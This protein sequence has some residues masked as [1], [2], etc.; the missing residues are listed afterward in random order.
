M[1]TEWKKDIESIIDIDDVVAYENET[2]KKWRE[3]VEER[4]AEICSF[5]DYGFCW[6]DKGNIAINNG[7]YC[8]W[9]EEYYGFFGKNIE[10][11]ITINENLDG[12]LRHYEYQSAEEMVKDW[13]SICRVTNDDYVKNGSEKPFKWL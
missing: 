8:G 9:H 4:M 5:Y 6:N 2:G 11:D 3:E 12:D 13:E 1:R 7:Y 10:E